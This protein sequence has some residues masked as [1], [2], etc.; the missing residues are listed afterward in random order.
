MLLLIR[1]IVEWQGEVVFVVIARTPGMQPHQYGQRR[2]ALASGQASVDLAIS[3]HLDD[4]LLQV[5]PAMA[6]PAA[7]ARRPPPAPAR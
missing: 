4:A 6:A 5:G 1:Q 2:G 7:P 3:R